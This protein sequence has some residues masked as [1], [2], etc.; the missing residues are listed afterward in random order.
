MRSQRRKDTARIKGAARR[1]CFDSWIVDYLLRS[2]SGVV[3]GTVLPIFI[4]IS[5]LE[6]ALLVQWLRRF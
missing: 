5:A 3:T 4:G 2:Q 6:A 1:N